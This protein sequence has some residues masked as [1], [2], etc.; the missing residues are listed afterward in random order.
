MNEYGVSSSSLHPGWRSAES[1]V[2]C[3]F[4]VEEGTDRR[5]TIKKQEKLNPRASEFTEGLRHFGD[6]FNLNDGDMH[7]PNWKLDYWSYY[8]DELLRVKVRY[9]PDGLFFC[10]QCV[11]S[12]LPYNSMEPSGSPVVAGSLYV[13][14]VAMVLS[15]GYRW[16]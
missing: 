9:D 13:A 15:I 3:Y 16:L 5:E 4:G 1:A 8:H 14:I 7:S 11:G 12:T 6:G 10:P 2:S